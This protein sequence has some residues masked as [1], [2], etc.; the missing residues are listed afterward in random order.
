MFP[1]TDILRFIALSHLLVMLLLFRKERDMGTGKGICLF[2]GSCIAGYLLA[3]WPPLVK[4]PLVYM[5]LLVLP[6]L[7][8]A[9]FWLFSKW[10]F[11]DGFRWR[12]WWAWLLVSV[13]AVSYLLFFQNKF[14]VFVLPESLRLFFG[15]LSQLISLT[16]IL[17]G[18]IEATRNREADLILSRLQFRTVFIIATALLMAVTA[19]VEI[20]LAG[21]KAPAELEVL[22]KAAIAGLII[23][24]SLNR[25]AFKR[26]F[27]PKYLQPA[28][29]LPTVPPEADERL[30]TKLDDL[31]E[32][33]KIWR[34]EGLTIRQL[35]EK[36]DVKEYRLRQAIN[37]HLNFRN[38]NDYLHSKRIREACNMLSDPANHDL[39]ILEITYDLGYASLAP[40]NKAFRDLTG[41]TPTEWRREHTP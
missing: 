25:L 10:L 18:I 9:A 4:Y 37:Q 20:S 17:L 2:L 31:M 29:V 14:Q 19:L 16:F 21:A 36:M 40:F 34:T 7:A 1:L 11:D 23:F 6:F 33:Q 41:K 38:F 22:Q 26:G 15:L 39:T 5:P 12:Q 27:F 30:L 3:D 35:A 13:V 24:F 8:P 28:A 32:N